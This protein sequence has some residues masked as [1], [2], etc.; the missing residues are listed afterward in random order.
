VFSPDFEDKVFYAGNNQYTTGR[1]FNNSYIST[2]DS[3]A[4]TAM[5]YINSPY[6]WVDA[7]LQEL[8]VQ[9]LPNWL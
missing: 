4:D 6:I 3:L 8:T 9:D 5:R 7:Y 1:E 2:N